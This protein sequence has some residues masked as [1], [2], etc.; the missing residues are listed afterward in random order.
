VQAARPLL[1]EESK[2]PPSL[3]TECQPLSQ[4]QAELSA[5]KAQVRQAT[6]EQRQPAT[7][8]QVSTEIPQ[9]HLVTTGAIH[10][11]QAAQASAQAEVQAIAEAPLAEDSAQ[12]D[13]P[14]AE[15]HQ[16]AGD[17]DNSK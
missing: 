12:A 13:R 15:V 4:L 7:G 11:R 6:T 2:G 16:E 14:E 8:R 9:A 17:K 3:T 1:Q 10:P 5:G